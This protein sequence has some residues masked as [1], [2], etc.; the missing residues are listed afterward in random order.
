ML[1]FQSYV[2]KCVVGA[3][4]AYAA[5]AAYGVFLNSQAVTLHRQIF[6]LLPGFSW[7]APGVIIGGLSIAVWSIAFGVYMVWMHNSSLTK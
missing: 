1:S 2:W 4:V 5:C 3:E 6:E 7:S